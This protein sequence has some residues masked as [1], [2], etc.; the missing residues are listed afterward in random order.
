[1]P[2]TALVDL[3]RAS[4]HCVVLTGAGISTLS[5]IPDFRGKNGFY[6]RTD[7]DAQKLFDLA[8]FMRDPDYYYRH[9][10]DFIYNLADKEPNIIHTQLARLEELGVVKAVLTQNIDLLHQKAGSRHVLELHGSPSRHRCLHCGREF[11][12]DAIV[13][14]LDQGKSPRCDAC[15]G[16]VKPDI[17]FFGEPLDPVVLGEADDEA[18]RAD[19]MLVLG[20]SLTVYPAAGLPVS[21]LRQ[22]GRLAIVN[23]DP[24]PLDSRAVWRHPDLA[25]AFTA[26][27]DALDAGDLAPRA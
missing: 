14:L 15:G 13:E 11:S 4:R 18:S 22:G 19:L 6:R 27:R 23:A 20:S 2:S 12:F 25:E 1:M 21:T 9:S 3:L 5:G 17:I 7:V 26:V 8:Y 16:I 10:R 24:T